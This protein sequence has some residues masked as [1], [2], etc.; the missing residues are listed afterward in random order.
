MSNVRPKKV[1]CPNCTSWMGKSLYYEHLPCGKSSLEAVQTKGRMFILYQM[2]NC[3][4]NTRPIDEIDDR[5][6]KQLQSII[7]QFLLIDID[8][9]I[10]NP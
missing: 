8:Q 6:I 5:K 1:Y 4:N 9:S 3:S 2:T 10:A 7:D